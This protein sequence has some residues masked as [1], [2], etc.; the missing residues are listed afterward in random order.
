VPESLLPLAGLMFA[1]WIFTANVAALSA[2]GRTWMWTTVLFTVLGLALSFALLK[3]F[4]P[5][6]PFHLLTDGWLAVSGLL[7][8]GGTI[9]AYAAARKK[10]LISPATMAVAGCVWLVISMIV[11]FLWQQHVLPNFLW[12]WNG[13][14]LAALG[15]LPLATMPLAV[16]WN[17]HR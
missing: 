17:R 15:V 3:Q 10:E 13:M 12:A 11:L 1:S 8:L 6:A 4:I 16:R 7:Y 5:P 2:T 9:W 14:G